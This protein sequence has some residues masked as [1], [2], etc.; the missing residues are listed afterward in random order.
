MNRIKHYRG[1]ADISQSEL[2]KALGYKQSAISNYENC[3]RAPSVHDAKRIIEFFRSKGLDISFDD[4]FP[5][6]VA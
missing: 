1:V 6:E 5:A 4:V 2:A 3:S